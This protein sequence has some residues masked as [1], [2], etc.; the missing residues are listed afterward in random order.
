MDDGRQAKEASVGR[1]GLSL[2]RARNTVLFWCPFFWRF[3]SEHDD[4][5]QKF[6]SLQI[7][8]YCRMLG[9]RYDALD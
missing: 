9:W 2:K 7:N 8:S 1:A 4:E 5:R 3:P 6:Q